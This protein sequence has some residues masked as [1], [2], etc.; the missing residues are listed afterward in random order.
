MKSVKKL[1]WGLLAL[2]LAFCMTFTGCNK[3]TGSN[4]PEEKDESDPG[5]NQGGG[6]GKTDPEKPADD[7]DVTA[8]I[9]G[10]EITIKA[11]DI[12]KIKANDKIDFDAELPA[13]VTIEKKD[14][15]FTVTVAEDVADGQ[16]S[17]NL[18]A[19]EN[20]D[21]I[22]VTVKVTNPIY[23]LTIALDDA[24]AAKAAAIS[25]EYGNTDKVLDTVEATYKAGEKTAVAK[26]KKEN[27][28]EWDWFSPVK[29]IIKD[30]DGNEITIAQSVAYF[31]YSASEGNG[32]I[33]N[34]TVT[35]AMGV[36][37]LTFTVT[38]EGFTAKEISGIVYTKVENDFDT[39][40]EN[41]KAAEAK[42]ADD[43]KSATFAVEKA[44]TNNSG[45]FQIKFADVVAKDADGKEVTITNKENTWFE[46]KEGMTGKLSYV[47]ISTDDY[48]NT[49]VSDVA[50]PAETSSTSVVLLK[51]DLTVPADAK[52]FKLVYTAGD[53]DI[54]GASTWIS[55]YS[56][57]SWANETKLVNAWVDGFDASAKT[58]TICITDSDAVEAFV[59]GNFYIAA[60]SA[61]Y[62]GKI[63]ITYAK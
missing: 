59:K 55:I 27:A 29:V 17:L 14:G 53:N 42:V 41:A 49:L 11:G 50:L 44:Y 3:S 47:A 56:S 25:V 35:V 13:G 23:Y 62:T 31:C 52:A 63:T 21:G 60:D 10:A 51:S 20:D 34:R 5:T 32:Y 61:A 19:D 58:F 9:D 37:E 7:Q 18:F 46:Y 4:T 40:G 15:V 24:V 39:T 48:K 26:L 12:I 33:E 8:V 45:W 36:A 57:D 1:S 38:F 16:F 6:N 54:V 30:A 43:G 28:D 22:N 2:C